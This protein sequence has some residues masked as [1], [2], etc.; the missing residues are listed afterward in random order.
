MTARRGAARGRAEAM[1]FD[2]KTPGDFGVEPQHGFLPGTDGQVTIVAVQ[3]QLDRLVGG[4][5]KLEDRPLGS[6]YRPVRAVD[7]AGAND[8]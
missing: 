4:K 5:R 1:R 2:G 7:A 8:N 6:P 3:V